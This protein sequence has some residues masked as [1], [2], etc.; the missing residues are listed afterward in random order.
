MRTTLEILRGLVL[1]GLVAAICAGLYRLIEWQA[2]DYDAHSRGLWEGV[3][4][5]VV[6][7]AGTSIAQ[8]I[9]KRRRSRRERTEHGAPDAS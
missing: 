7:N 9:M 6:G 1:G 5:V 4:V 2:A 8:G 3:L